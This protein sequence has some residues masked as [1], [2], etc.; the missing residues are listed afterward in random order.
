MPI[1]LACG[2]VD[3]MGLAFS[4]AFFYKEN[5]W[6]PEKVIWQEKGEQFGGAASK[7]KKEPTD[8]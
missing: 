1:P 3:D 2:E 5:V 7:I 6:T 4:H 8:F